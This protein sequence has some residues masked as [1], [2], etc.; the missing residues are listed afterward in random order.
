MQDLVFGT[1]IHRRQRVVEDQDFRV[2]QQGACDGNTL[3]LTTGK[4][5]ATLTHLGFIALR[6][7]QNIL[8]HAGQAGR[9]L[10]LF[11]RRPW[12]AERDVVCHAV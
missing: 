8:V 12:V 1:A 9:T 7:A 11:L 3:F 4:H 2:Q 5:H 6:Q 10:N